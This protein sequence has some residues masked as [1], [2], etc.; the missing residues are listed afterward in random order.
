MP[1]KKVLFVDDE[2]SLLEMYRTAFEKKGYKVRTAENAEEALALLKAEAFPVMFF[3]IMM[4]GMNGIDLFKEVIKIYP[5]AVVYVVTGHPTVFEQDG[6][7]AL[8]IKGYFAKPASLP[9]L[10]MAAEGA[11]AAGERK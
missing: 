2:I 4:P 10:Y 7:L 8:G 5:D 9:K 6:C 3:D 11:F 1:E